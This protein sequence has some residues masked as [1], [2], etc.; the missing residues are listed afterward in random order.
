MTDKKISLEELSEGQIRCLDHLMDAVVYTDRMY[1]T[2][3]KQFPLD[4]EES[5][6]IKDALDRT[7]NGMAIVIV[8]IREYLADEVIEKIIAD[9]ERANKEG[10]SI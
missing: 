9:L 5:E 2:L 8:T 1:K 4:S 10:F 3:E 6:I 7:A